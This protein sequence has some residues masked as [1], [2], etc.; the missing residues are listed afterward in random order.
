MAAQTHTTNP[1]CPALALP[2]GSHVS[3]HI[4]EELADL[5][6]RIRRLDCSEIRLVEATPGHHYRTT[7]PTSSGLLWRLHPRLRPPEAP[8]GE[9]A[10]MRPRRRRAKP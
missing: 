2:D 10:T 7:F 6:D 4:V 9:Q 3:P 5:F 1:H 8:D